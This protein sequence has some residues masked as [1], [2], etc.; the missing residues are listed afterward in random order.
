MKAKTSKIKVRNKIRRESVGERIF[1]GFNIA[2]L[3]FL[4]ICMIYPLWHVVCASLSNPSYIA[5]YNGMLLMPVD[6]NGSFSATI[7]AYKQMLTHPLIVPAY[8]N[9]IFIVVVGTTINIILTSICAYVLSRKKFKLKKALTGFVMF[10][11]FFHGGMIPTYVIVADVLGLRDSYLSLILPGAISVYNMIVMRT[12]FEGLPESLDEAAQVDGAGHLR[13]L[14][15]IVLPLS[16][17]IIAVMILYYA[18]AHWNSWFNASIYL[19]DRGKF[20]LQ[21]ILREIL[22][23]NDVSS[24]GGNASASAASDVADIGETLKYATIIFATIPILCVY[25]FLQKY[26]TKGV[27]IGAVKG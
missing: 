9:S 10:T 6:I 11:M 14:F 20:P 18:V 23:Q 24:M 12:S 7:S 22:L 27:M 13:I 25:P 5:S 3:I 4:S 21:L 8:A 19:R 2:F 1:N 17:A 16:K 26:F 15:Q